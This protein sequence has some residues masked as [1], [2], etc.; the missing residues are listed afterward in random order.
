M[1]GIKKAP[2]WLIA[3]LAFVLPNCAYANNFVDALDLTPFVPLVIQAMMGIAISSYKFFV[4]SNGSGIINLIIIGFVGLSIALYLVKMYL[5][6]TWLDNFGFSGGGEMVEGKVDAWKITENVLKPMVRAIIA[7]TFLLQVKPTFV[8]NWLAEPFLS[9]GAIY[10]EHILKGMH[11]TDIP[12][13]TDVTCPDIIV[14]SGWLSETSCKFLT[15]PVAN[16][17]SANNRMIVRGLRMMKNGLRDLMTIVAADGKDFLSVI[18]GIILVITFVSSNVFMALLVIQGIFD[19]GLQLILYPFNVLTYVTKPNDKWLDLWPAFGGLTKALQTLI[20]T[21]ISCAFIMCIN[22]AVVK[23]LF[24]RHASVFNAAAGGSSSSNVPHDAAEM[25]MTFAGF[26]D[27][28][29]TWLSAILTFYLM[30]KIFDMT[31]KQL[32]KYVGSGQDALHKQVMGDVKGLYNS[33][34][35]LWNFGKTATG[36]FKKYK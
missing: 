21:M 27:H 19:F 34:K 14:E 9:F 13:V 4:G 25:A 35:G 3:F 1:L 7:L 22:I 32:L 20:I 33:G 8:T 30:Y 5:P 24:Q 10:T 2:F 23:A 18:T 26:G 29:V 28:S 16:L 11:S 36:F 17:S 12:T 15:Q 31:Q 6:K